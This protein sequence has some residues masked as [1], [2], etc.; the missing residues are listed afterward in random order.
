MVVS[1]AVPKRA[2]DDG[3]NPIPLIVSRKY[4]PPASIGSGAIPLIAGAAA[5]IPAARRQDSQTTR[6]DIGRSSAFNEVVAH[7]GVNLR[8]FCYIY[9]TMNRTSIAR[10]CAAAA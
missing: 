9:G 5:H 10:L 8:N 2:T 7:P 3:T 4:G 6:S 1:A